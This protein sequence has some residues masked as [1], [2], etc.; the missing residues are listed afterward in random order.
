MAATR[1]RIGRKLVFDSAR[2]QTPYPTADLPNFANESRLCKNSLT[3]AEPDGAPSTVA[4]ARM[5]CI[6]GP[7]PRICITRFML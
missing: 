6:S 5:A 7:A 4:Q 2:G 1:R 3:E